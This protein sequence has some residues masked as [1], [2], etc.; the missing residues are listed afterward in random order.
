M[1][2][3]NDTILLVGHGSREA[4]G[5]AEILLFAERWRA[6][7]PDWRIDV[8][9]IEFADP[10]LDPALNHAARNSGRVL[11]LP[12]ILN[13][14]G[15]VRQDI[16]S[17][18]QRARKRHPDVQFLYAPHLAV[19]DPLLRILKRFLRQAMLQLDV[20]DPRT[21]GVILLGRG[22]SDRLANGDVARM[23]R[24]LWEIGDHERVDL[25][26][27]GVTFP[28]LEKVVRDQ[29]ALGMM[30]I[31]VMPYY[32]FTGTLIKR[33]GR[34]MENLAAQYP[35]VRFAHTSY[36]GFEP[37]I[38]RML[39]ERVHA[40]KQG[41]GAI[42]L[43]RLMR[44]DPFRE[45]EGYHHHHH[46]GH[47]H[48]GHGHGHGH[49]HDHEAHDHGDDHSHDAHPD[50]AHD[51]P[52]G[53]EHD[54]AHDHDHDHEHGHS[55]SHDAEPG[56][57]RDHAHDPDHDHDHDH[58]QHHDHA[59]VEPVPQGNDHQIMNDPNQGRSIPEVARAVPQGK[60]LGPQSAFPK[61][62]AIQPGLPGRPFFPRSRF[63]R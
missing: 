56:H 24:W 61:G 11:V 5:N 3:S 50:H 34:Q 59:R 51:H 43:D 47:D 25:A 17:A 19:S 40:L 62:K 32:L 44:P 29:V 4:S 48:H 41:V 21:T 31:V 49:G 42:D 2:T 7:H 20:P 6:R 52:H 39:D 27:T 57:D 55:H 58:E 54:H 15:H 1:T 35:Q 13:A 60:P 37:E 12:L 8:G 10:L 23:A 16:P 18:I 38:A 28:R 33:I 45:S 53:H 63:G 46:H 22:S 36:F 26:F 9:F 14:A 30:Q